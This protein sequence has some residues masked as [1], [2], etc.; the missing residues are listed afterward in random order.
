MQPD[1]DLPPIRLLPEHRWQPDVEPSDDAEQLRQRDERRATALSWLMAAAA[2]AVLA[3][4]LTWGH[5]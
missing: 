2:I 4:A 5:A 1:R 3:L